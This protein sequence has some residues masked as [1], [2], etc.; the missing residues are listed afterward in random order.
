MHER[1]NIPNSPGS[2]EVCKVE[3]EKLI[4]LS[5][6]AT[7]NGLTPDLSQQA[8]TH[9]MNMF[10]ITT[11]SQVEHKINEIYIFWA[12]VNDGSLNSK[13]RHDQAERSVGN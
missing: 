8:T 12:E 9:F 5:K 10:A 7:L 11:P 6:S 13:N 1:L 4:S 3:L 2:L